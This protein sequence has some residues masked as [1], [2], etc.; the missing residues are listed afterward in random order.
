MIVIKGG[1]VLTTEGWANVDV[2]VDEGVI[3]EMGTDVDPGGAGTIDAAGMYVGPGLVDLHTHLRE[4]GQTWKE[5]ISSG[6]RSAAAGGFTAVVAMPNTDPPIDSPKIV[7]EVRRRGQEVG[8]VDVSVA[9]SLTRGRSGVAVSDVEALYEAGVRV[10][11]DDGDSVADTEVMREAMQVIG[12]LP[13]AV[14][15]QHAE[16]ASLTIGGHLNEGPIAEQSGIGA[17]PSA[18]EVRILERD[19]ALVRET[20]TRYHFQHVSSAASVELLRKAKAEG[21]PVTSEVA[22]HHLT[23]EDR[24]LRTLDTNF[25]M[26]PPIRSDADRSALREALIDRTIDIVATDHAPHTPSEK[27]VS[28]EQAPRGVIGLETAASAVFEVVDSVGLLFEVMS[29]IPARIGGFDDQGRILAP[30]AS[31]NLTVFDPNERWV[32]EM[33]ASKSANSPYLGRE[34]TGRV[35][36]T[37][38]GGNVVYRMEPT[39]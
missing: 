23:F 19:L 2:L 12:R 13:G 4:P 25:K 30:G 22:P 29:L 28:F 37:I 15:A 20:G 3:T 6:S 33:F 31:A 21:L 38:S 24:A 5:D 8:I 14:V 9:A 1:R 26:Y 17:L 35:K 16:D 18:A 7:G 34:M 36:A 32:P 10:F 11:T 39:A 27:D